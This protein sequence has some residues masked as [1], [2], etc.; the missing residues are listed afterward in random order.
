MK[1][2]DI[3]T[4]TLY[5]AVYSENAEQYWYFSLQ[6]YQ[7]YSKEQLKAD[8]EIDDGILTDETELQYTYYFVP[9]LMVNLTEKMRNYLHHLNNRQIEKKISGLNDDELYIYFQKYLEIVPSYS[10][11]EYQTKCQT[12]TAIAFCEQY[13]IPYIL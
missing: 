2:A 4:L 9:L 1:K 5:N 8:F 3:H 7:V 10:W 12:E 6:D 11:G 13:H